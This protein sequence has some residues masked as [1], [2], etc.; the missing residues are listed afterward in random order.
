MLNALRTYSDSPRLLAVFVIALGIAWVFGIGLHEFSHALAAYLQGDTT[1][2]RQGRL[3]VNP[4]AHMDPTGTTLFLISGFFGWGKPTPFNPF[5][6]KWGPRL[7]GALVAVAGPLSNFLM[8]IIF[9]LP[10]TLRLIHPFGVRI[11]AESIYTISPRFLDQWTAGNY[12]AA[13]LYF[14]VLFNVSVGLFNLLPIF[15]LDGEKVAVG[16]LP[17]EMGDVFMRLRPYGIGILM[18]LLILPAFLPGFNLIGD[19]IGPLLD[20]ITRAILGFRVY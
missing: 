18:L 14:V 5:K 15:P 4:I 11:G 17:R 13:V 9:A 20:N 16:V 10:M 19:V 6:L 8:A 2:E 3:T 7:G 12:I 1:A